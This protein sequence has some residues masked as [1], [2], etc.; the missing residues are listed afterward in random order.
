M[1]LFPDFHRGMGKEDERKPTDK[2]WLAGQENK[3]TFTWTIRRIVSWILQSISGQMQVKQEVLYTGSFSYRVLH[4]KIVLYEG[5]ILL[6]D[7]W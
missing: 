1:W 2:L 7:M 4:K 3:E 5:R 6:P